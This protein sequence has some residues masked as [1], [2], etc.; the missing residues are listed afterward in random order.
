M[1]PANSLSTERIQTVTSMRGGLGRTLLSAFLL[2]AII[3]LAI[4]SFLAVSGRNAI[5]ATRSQ[6]D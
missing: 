5:S 3:P 2:L 6:P 1:R 4:I